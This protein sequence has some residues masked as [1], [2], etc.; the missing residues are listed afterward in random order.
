MRVVHEV[1]KGLGFSIDAREQLIPTGVATSVM[2]DEPNVVAALAQLPGGFRTPPLADI[3][4][5]DRSPFTRQVLDRCKANAASA[6]GHDRDLAFEPV[7]DTEDVANWMP[8]SA[9]S[10]R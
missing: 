9:Q 10:L 8:R 4:Q 7:H 6:A 3:T 5:I 2:K 1:M